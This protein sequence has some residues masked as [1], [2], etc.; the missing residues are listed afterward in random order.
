MLE[1]VD[2]DDAPMMEE[3]QEEEEDYDDLDNFSFLKFASMYF[4]GSATPSHIRQRLRQ[5]LLYH[6]DEGDVLVP[7]QLPASIL[8]M[9]SSGT[10]AS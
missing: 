5:P 9:W 4:Q 1:E 10:L 3:P 6:D 8:L 7:S 2:L